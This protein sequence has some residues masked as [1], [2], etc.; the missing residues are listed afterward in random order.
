MGWETY[1]QVGNDKD[2]HDYLGPSSEEKSNH[3]VVPTQ[4]EKNGEK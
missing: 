2:T 4:L 3:G 1:H